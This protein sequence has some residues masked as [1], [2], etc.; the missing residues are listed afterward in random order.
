MS[1][2]INFALLVEMITYIF[3]K[4]IYKHS[5]LLRINLNMY[6]LKFHN[7]EAYNIVLLY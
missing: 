3:H 4:H 2:S 1:I 5:I 7:A 6:N